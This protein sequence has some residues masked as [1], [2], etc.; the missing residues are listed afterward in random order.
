MKYKQNNKLPPKDGFVG[1]LI[2]AQ[3]IFDIEGILPA[4]YNT[5]C[6]TDGIFVQAS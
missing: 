1:L 3:A 2:V 5:F 4:T 6:L